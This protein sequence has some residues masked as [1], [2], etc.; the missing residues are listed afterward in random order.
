MK[1]R[2]NSLRRCAVRLVVLRS[3]FVYFRTLFIMPPRKQ[4][5]SL[6]ALSNDGKILLTHI[7]NSFDSFKDEIRKEFSE[8][9]ESKS[10]EVD[11]LK[12]QVVS[13]QKDLKTLRN[14]IDAQDQYVRKDSIIFSGPAVKNMEE[15]ENCYE[16]VM[17]LVKN[18]LGVEIDERDINILHR[19]G[20][21][22]RA[23][24]QTSNRSIYV[25]LVRRDK[26]REIIK[27]SKKRTSGP[28][29]YC[30]ESLSPLRRSMYFALRKMKKKHPSIVKGCLTMDG[31]IYAFTPAVAQGN[32]DQR[33][34]IS[35]MDDLKD[36]CRKHVKKPMEDF[37]EN[38]QA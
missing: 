10:E 9:L 29:L 7:Q 2:V 11:I 23:Q 30:N 18:K 16:I 32:R 17:D 36:F 1:H 12:T 24:A 34:Y 5:N 37:L 26:K 8:L 14:D 31:K 38:F 19:L 33:H 4:A 25:K 35:D 15:D 21:K 27:A 28:A 13:L 6:D 22:N 3:L 20:P